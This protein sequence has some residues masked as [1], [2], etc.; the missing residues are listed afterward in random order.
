MLQIHNNH[1]ILI[2]ASRT[3]PVGRERHKFSEALSC[4]A[5]F[6]Q[7]SKG[8]TESQNK[9]MFLAFPLNSLE[10]GQLTLFFTFV[11]LPNT[12][13]L[14]L[15]QSWLHVHSL[16]KLK[17]KIQTSHLQFKFM[18]VLKGIQH[19]FLNVDC[20]DFLHCMILI[21][22]FLCRHYRGLYGVG[23]GL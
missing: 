13:T 8:F 22:S 4:F 5:L 10:F 2:F 21:T 7:P 6:H 16:S 20:T 17:K 19:N 12:A 1:E 11:K 9:L 3:A 15:W 18:Q 23:R 14:T